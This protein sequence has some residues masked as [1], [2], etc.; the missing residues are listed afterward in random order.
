MAAAQ[1]L[2]KTSQPIDI[3][4]QYNLRSRHIASHLNSHVQ[5]LA[6]TSFGSFGGELPAAILRQTIGETDHKFY[7][8]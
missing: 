4:C 2:H 8:L 5:Q 6:D 7:N 3:A 1:L